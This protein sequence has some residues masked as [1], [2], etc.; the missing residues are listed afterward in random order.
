ML[1]GGRIVRNISRACVICR[2]RHCKSYRYPPSPPLIPL[3]L[4]DLRPFFTGGIEKFGPV[5]LET[6]TLLKMTLCTRHGL[7]CKHALPEE[8]F[9]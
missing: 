7:H 5:F 8:P 2:K 3:R 6:F 4:N 9:V 1:C